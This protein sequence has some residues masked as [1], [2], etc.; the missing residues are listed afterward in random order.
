MKAVICRKFGPPRE[1]AVEDVPAPKA[2][3]GQVVIAVKACGVNFPDTLIVEGKYQFKPD[4]PFSPGGE[5][6]GVV[7]EIGEGVGGVK[8]GDRVAAMTIFGGFAEQIVT[9][10]AQLIPLPD[11]LDLAVAACSMMT[12]GTSWHALVDR[13]QLRAGET[14]LVLGAAGGVG[15][16]AVEIGK[17][18][19]ARVIA[20]ASSPSKLELCR[21]YGADASIEYTREDLKQKVKELTGGGGADVVYDP[22]GGASTEAAIRGTGWNGRVLVIGFASG[23]IPRIPVNLLLLKG[24]S[25]VGVFWGQFMMREPARGRAQLLE[26]LERIRDGKL[27]PHISGRYP[28]ADAPRALEEIA[29]RK[30]QGKLVLIP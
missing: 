2:G 12:Y 9:S 20:A 16:A 19:G 14:L 23:E 26:I 5:V 10:A 17:Q 3:P 27:R 13:A 30:V 18:L 28:L 8:V 11:G 22:V 29:A 25:L 24:A 4:P 1:L 6:A 21:K 7:Q 15:L